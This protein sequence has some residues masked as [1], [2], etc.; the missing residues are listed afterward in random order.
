M[1]AQ[2]TSCVVQRRPLALCGCLRRAPGASLGVAMPR[3]AW[4]HLALRVRAAVSVRHRDAPSA[5]FTSLRVDAPRCVAAPRAAVCV[6]AERRSLAFP[7]TSCAMLQFTLCV[8]A[9]RLPR[10]VAISVWHRDAPY[11]AAPLRACAVVAHSAFLPNSGKKF[12]C[13]TLRG[14]AL[15]LMESGSVPSK[16]TLSI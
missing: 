8:G 9:C 6:H 11:G 15:H 14:T 4:R 16:M 10:C 13:W 7:T 12:E 5:G 3:I 2:R 1:P